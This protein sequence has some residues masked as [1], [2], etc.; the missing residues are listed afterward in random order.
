MKCSVFIATSVDGFIAK[1]DGSVDW[2]HTAENPEADMGMNEYMSS[3]DCMIMGRKCMDMISSMNLTP[4]QWPYENTKI[5]VLSNTLKE[6]P[7]NLK[8]KVEM[9]SGDLQVLVSKLE[10]KGFKH[11]YI[12]GGT[13]VQAFINL[14][15][16]NEITITRIPILLGKGKPLF[17]KTFKD[18]K[19]E[20]AKAIVFPNDFIQLKYKVNYL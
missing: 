14:K 15:L 6:A 11:A 3:I 7:E 19:L 13:T 12:D 8:G 20:E 5:I 1:E 16:I 2:L 10:N 18:I 4:E 9:Y 17:G